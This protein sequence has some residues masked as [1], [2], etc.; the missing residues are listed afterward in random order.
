MGGDI[1]VSG[2]FK[3]IFR[4]FRLGVFFL[5]FLFLNG[6]RNGMKSKKL[7]RALLCPE[8]KLLWGG[9]VQSS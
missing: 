7:P 3:G 1:K 9:N 4:G 2:D 6:E 8:E 5:F